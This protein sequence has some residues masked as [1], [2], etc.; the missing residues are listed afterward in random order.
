M[1][2]VRQIDSPPVRSV[3]ATKYELRG[4]ESQTNELRVLSYVIRL[5]SDAGITSVGDTNTSYEFMRYDLRDASHDLCGKR[6][7]CCEV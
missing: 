7:R 1:E 6:V 2:W 5:G 4:D 3:G